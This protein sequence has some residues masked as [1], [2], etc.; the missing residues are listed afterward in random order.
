VNK[1]EDVRQYQ[2]HHQ[3]VM[4]AAAGSAL[5]NATNVTG[6]LDVPVP[7]RDAPRFPHVAAYCPE[8][9]DAHP[10]GMQRAAS[11]HAGI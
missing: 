5:A 3:R 7:A 4:A 1:F 6:F 10:Q 2:H 9:V 11:R 8:H